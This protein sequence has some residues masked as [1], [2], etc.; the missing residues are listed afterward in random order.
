MNTSSVQHPRSV[1]IGPLSLPTPIPLRFSTTAGGSL[2]PNR[3]EISLAVAS[4]TTT[5]NSAARPGGCHPGRFSFRSPH[6]GRPGARRPPTDRGRSRRSTR[7]RPH[8]RAL[9]RDPRRTGPHPRAGNRHER[10]EVGVDDH[11]VAGQAVEL[12]VSQIGLP[13]GTT[14]PASSPT[15]MGSADGAIWVDPRIGQRLG[16]RSAW[17]HRTDDRGGIAARLRT[18]AD[19][20]PVGR[21]FVLLATAGSDARARV[22]DTTPFVHVYDVAADTSEALAIA[23]ELAGVDEPPA[24]TT[25]PGGGASPALAYHLGLVGARGRDSTTPWPPRAP[26][27][28]TAAWV[29]CGRSTRKSALRPPP[30]STW[31]S[32]RRRR[33]WRS[34]SS[35]GS[36]CVVMRTVPSRRS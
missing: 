2:P 11:G 33:R 23:A 4:R 1:S 21:V 29:S 10:P 13:A 31:C 17:D 18:S 30:R 34:P 26:S 32:Y 24:L 3:S 8:Q 14:N 9:R 12:L 15:S 6:S 22:Y 25:P 20:E 35:S 28:P 27:A 36:T 7:H 16:D 5:A 19:H